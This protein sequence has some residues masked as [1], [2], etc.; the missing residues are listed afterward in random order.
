MVTDNWPPSA[1][2]GTTVRLRLVEA[3][4]RRLAGQERPD[5]ALLARLQG[6]RRALQAQLTTGGATGEGRPRA[7]RR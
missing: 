2:G 6:L 3:T 4:M 1:Q 7:V 5:F